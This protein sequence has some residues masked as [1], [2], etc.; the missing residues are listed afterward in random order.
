MVGGRPR[1]CFVATDEAGGMF[2]FL[3]PIE[4]SF[5]IKSIK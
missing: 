2:G 1:R 3:P 5:E 4:S